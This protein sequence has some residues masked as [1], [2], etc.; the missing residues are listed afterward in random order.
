M[1]T[2]YRTRVVKNDDVYDAQCACGFS[3]T[4]WALK[5]YADARIAEH[6]AEHESGEPMRELHDFRAEFGL[7]PDS[8]N[9][10]GF[11]DSEG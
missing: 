2:T 6:T 5:K 10:V 8:D 7:N 3:S 1:P 9:V 11:D 4:G